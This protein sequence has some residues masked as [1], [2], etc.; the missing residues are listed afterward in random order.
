MW[1]DRSVRLRDS[2]KSAGSVHLER[3]AVAEKISATARAWMV[4]FSTSR[5]R[6]RVQRESPLTC[7]GGFPH[8]ERR[9]NNLEHCNSEC[10]PSRFILGSMVQAWAGARV[11]I[12]ADRVTKEGS[13][14]LRN[15]G[16][17]Q[18]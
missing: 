11:A 5:E 15:T 12:Q 10:Q 9:F 8:S 1:L 3:C 2:E 6:S 7:S 16:N 13:S 17:R 4:G 18:G 14:L